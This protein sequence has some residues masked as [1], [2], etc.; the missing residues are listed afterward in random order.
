[1]RL[2][3]HV[4]FFFLVSQGI[5]D[6]MGSFLGDVSRDDAISPEMQWKLKWN[7]FSNQVDGRTSDRIHEVLSIEEEPLAPQRRVLTIFGDNSGLMME[8][9]SIT[10]GF[11][12]TLN[13]G[14]MFR[15]DRPGS[16][17]HYLT[18]MHMP[19]A[20]TLLISQL[21]ANKWNELL[22][23][24]KSSGIT[25]KDYE[26]P[27][28]A[29][30]FSM[31]TARAFEKT[32]RELE[33]RYHYDV[34]VVRVLTD[35]KK[36]AEYS[37]VCTRLPRRLSQKI[38][39]LGS[40]R[41]SFF[42][43]T[44]TLRRSKI[45]QGVQS[46]D[47]IE[48]SVVNGIVWPEGKLFSPVHSV[49]VENKLWLPPVVDSEQFVPA[50]RKKPVSSEKAPRLC[51]IASYQPRYDMLPQLL[52][53]FEPLL[54]L[55]PAARLLLVLGNAH[56]IKEDLLA[57]IKGSPRV[58]LRPPVNH[59][60][61]LELYRTECDFG[62]RGVHVDTAAKDLYNLISTKVLEM[63]SLGVPVILNPFAIHRRILGDDYPL[64]WEHSP[65]VSNALANAVVDAMSDR[66]VY[67]RASL[68]M[69]LFAKQFSTKSVSLSVFEQLQA[70]EQE[71]TRRQ[72]LQTSYC[73]ALKTS[74]A[75]SACSDFCK[76]DCFFVVSDTTI[77]H[78]EAWAGSVSW[79]AP[80]TFD[81]LRKLHASYLHNGLQPWTG[82]RVFV[83]NSMYDAEN[84]ESRPGQV[85]RGLIRD[86]QVHKLDNTK[87]V[88]LLQP[89][90][91]EDHLGN[92]VATVDGT[93]LPRF[94]IN[95]MRNLGVDMAPSKYVL[96]VDV[97]F[98]PGH[99]T[100][101]GIRS[102]LESKGSKCEK[103]ALAVAVFN[104]VRCTSLSTPDNIEV[105]NTR[106]ELLSLWRKGQVIP[107]KCQSLRPSIYGKEAS[108]SEI[109]ITCNY[110]PEYCTGQALTD[111]VR[112]SAA[113]E[114]YGLTVPRDNFETYRYEPY[115][116]FNKECP[117]I[118]RFPETFLSDMVDKVSWET[119][120]LKAG[121]DVWAH[122]DVFAVH[123]D[124]PRSS[125]SLKHN[126]AWI[127]THFKEYIHDGQ[128]RLTS[129]CRGASAGETC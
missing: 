60:T 127:Q 79:V 69:Y 120:V 55:V 87:I 126:Y 11:L 90:P 30:R 57:K 38:I 84:V 66:N 34:I 83:V 65:E 9:D 76:G 80:T 101:E 97:D 70:A 31:L 91:V 110:F 40:E 128:T 50:A 39:L 121:F 13:I 7:S 6:G 85:L 113:E 82:P 78:K 117:D 72:Q 104:T 94:P 44:S 106:Q 75:M 77:K 51:L 61:A 86:L 108:K 20:P 8:D 48:T 16:M 52:R 22:H 3:Y 26:K 49:I 100:Y 24:M 54:Q 109:D 92:F 12:Y 107:W 5:C 23:P 28:R 123:I 96:P 25:T 59:K 15:M 71:R 36:M 14:N 43:E 129:F 21:Q 45:V 89:K 125:V 124:H 119:D 98:V 105:P 114:P 102:F 2:L 63:G 116:A 73:L 93:H 56:L 122:P 64:Y 95:V 81:R 35:N 118:P 19:S 33:G 103:V 29:A 111:Y 32:L 53:D 47:E 88:L 41:R 1:M 4:V 68:A 62:I 17:T 99:E 27:F 112:W 67:S 37:H 18:A 58:E 42:P 46:L 10:G 115:L 74:S